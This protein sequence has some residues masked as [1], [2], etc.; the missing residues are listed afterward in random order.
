VL[1][2]NKEKEGEAM[3]QKQHRICFIH[4]SLY[5][6]QATEYYRKVSAEVFSDLRIISSRIALFSYFL[7]L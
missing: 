7:K 1:I 4:N 6:F 2:T 5:V 3:G